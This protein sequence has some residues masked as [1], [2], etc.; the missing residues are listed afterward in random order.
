MTWSPSSLLFRFFILALIKGLL[1]HFYLTKKRE[2]ERGGSRSGSSRI[3]MGSVAQGLAT[4]NDVGRL[5]RPPQPTNVEE[6]SCRFHMPLHY[7]RYTKAD[8]DSMPEWKLDCLLQD[9]GIPPTGDVRDKRRFAIGAF[10]WPT[11]SLN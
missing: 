8:Y 4:A 5:W 3:N 6:G 9:Y 7:P 1:H 11:C 10:L 2:E